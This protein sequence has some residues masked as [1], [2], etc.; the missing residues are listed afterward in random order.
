[1]RVMSWFL[2]RWPG[3]KREVRALDSQARKPLNALNWRGFLR[4]EVVILHPLQGRYCTQV[5]YQVSYV[6]KIFMVLQLYYLNHLSRIWRREKGAEQH[7]SGPW[8]WI[9]WEDK[10]LLVN[11]SMFRVL[12]NY[13]CYSPISSKSRDLHC[14]VLWKSSSRRSCEFPDG[15][16]HRKVHQLGAI[17]PRLRVDLFFLTFCLPHLSSSRMKPTIHT[18]LSSSRYFTRWRWGAPS[19]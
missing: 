4:L 6:L 18:I 14:S 17:L 2:P 1:M 19:T 8:R 12:A 7:R 5:H 15:Q 3:R 9:F 10:M 13:C 11:L 16:F